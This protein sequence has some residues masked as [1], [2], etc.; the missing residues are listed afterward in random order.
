MVGCIPDVLT[1]LLT[2]ILQEIATFYARLHWNVA[3]SI[4]IIYNVVKNTKVIGNV[5][6]QSVGC[7]D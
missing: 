7:L 4:C 6:L 1:L 2:P 3:Q 5:D